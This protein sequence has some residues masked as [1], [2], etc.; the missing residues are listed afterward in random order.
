MKAVIFAGAKIEDYEFCKEYLDDVDILICC[1]A[2]MEHTKALGLTP[3]YIVGDF[4]SVG[5]DVLEFY[6]EKNIP[7]YQFPAK[8][9]QT[10]MQLGIHLALEKGATDLI[11]FGGIGSRFDHT[12]ANAHLLLGL[13]KKGIR[14]RLVDENNC[15]EL[16]DKPIT[17]H[18]KVGDLVST[19]P[20]SMMVRGIT[21]TGFA[22]PLTNRD[23]A[24]DDELVAVSNV[25]AQE[26]G[27]IYLTEGYLFVI[28]SKD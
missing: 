5:Q 9:D 12:L 6:K 1:D 23:L 14:A 20:L 26:D 4:D 8:K 28:H 21:L 17:I 18:G 2:G 22:Y 10:D 7:I 11:L 27:K 24:L 15:I 3:D 13:L 16:V 19:I 25:L